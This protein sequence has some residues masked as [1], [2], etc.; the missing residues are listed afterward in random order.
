MIKLIQ[1]L[2]RK[3]QAKYISYL[4]QME[5]ALNIDKHDLHSTLN[6]YLNRKN[7]N[8]DVLSFL[9]KKDPLFISFEQ[10][11][12]PTLER[13]TRICDLNYLDAQG[14]KLAHYYIHAPNYKYDNFIEKIKN[15]E[16]SIIDIKLLIDSTF[17]HGYFICGSKLEDLLESKK[18]NLSQTFFFENKMYN[19]CEYFLLKLKLS[20]TNSY[21]GSYWFI[22]TIVNLVLKHTP[23][24][25]N[26]TIYQKILEIMINFDEKTKSNQLEQD[27][28]LLKTKL[29]TLMLDNSIKVNKKTKNIQFK[30]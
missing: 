26:Q 11:H 8:Y 30:I 1:H 20:Q 12:C 13:L 25:I 15:V 18:I 3:K 9:D 6:H 23:H 16:L 2:K 7:I 5:K 27:F 17:K 4:V 19:F 22:D 21:Y 10:I 24:L 14:M 29:E 28:S